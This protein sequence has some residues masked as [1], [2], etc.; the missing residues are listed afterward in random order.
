MTEPD[1]AITD[2]I[3]AIETAL[4]VAMLR[5]RSTGSATMRFWSSML[6]GSLCAASL[7][8]GLTHGFFLDESSPGHAILWPVTLLAVGVTALSLAAI[9]GHIRFRK[10]VAQT[11]TLAAAAAVLVYALVIL[12]VKAEFFV[13]ILAY[14]PALLFFLVVLLV[15]W[16]RS[17]ERPLLDGAVAVILTL[18]ASGIQQA[19]FSL[20]GIPHAN[21]VLYHILEAVALFIL[22]RALRWMGARKTLPL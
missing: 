4:F 15:L 9:A 16:Q 12:F 8:G 6:F 5:R 10:D 20:P 11:I 3:L 17:R 14:L 2:F 13:A 7:A 22:F 18:V 19:G 21:N 1:V